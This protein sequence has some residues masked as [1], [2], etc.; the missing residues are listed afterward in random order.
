VVNQFVE[1]HRAGTMFGN[2]MLRRYLGSAEHLK[3][4]AADAEQRKLR[5]IRT[6]FETYAKQYDLDWLLVAAQAYQESQFDQTRRSHVGAVGVMQIKP[7]T[8]SDRNVAVANIEQVE[9]NIHAGIKYLRFIADRY[10]A[11]TGI[12][13]L[14]RGLFTL[15]AYNAGPGR[16]RQLR[17]KAEAAGLD[18]N[19]WFHNV[20]IIAARDI[21]RETVDYVSNIYKYFV[22]FKARAAAQDTTSPAR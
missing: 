21:G 3:N 13:R 9:N 20:E 18:Q 7:E 12:T 5:E 11:D 6:Y 4:P 17:R 22:V 8:A 19:V 15:A 2:V 10:Y 16:V 1:T 14:N